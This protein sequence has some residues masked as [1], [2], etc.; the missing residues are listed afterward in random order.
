MGAAKNTQDA[1]GPI[2]AGP[3]P[4]QPLGVASPARSGSGDPY[5][6]YNKLGGTSPTKPPPPLGPVPRG[7][8][9][10]LA[11]TSGNL[12]SP[13][14]RADSLA[15]NQQRTSW[16]DAKR[17]TGSSLGRIALDLGINV[18]GL[19]PN[20][21]YGVLRKELLSSPTEKDNIAKSTGISGGSKVV[22]D[23]LDSPSVVTFM[24]G[25]AGDTGATP[26]SIKASILRD[27][28]G[29]NKQRTRAVLE[30]LL[31]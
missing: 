30:Y 1:A 24:N 7:P 10:N 20:R 31:T 13:G 14:V 9:T 28:P 11:Y 18:A 16:D 5:D 8:V 22:G 25:I 4:T 3:R 12:R 17:I 27:F 19:D 21:V 29:P 26:A 6:V 15:M 23:I 2:A